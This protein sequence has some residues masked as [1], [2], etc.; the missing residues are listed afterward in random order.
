M[1]GSIVPFLARDQGAEEEND[2]RG[3][4]DTLWVVLGD[5]MRVKNKT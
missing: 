1:P 2:G 4:V 3:E 5:F